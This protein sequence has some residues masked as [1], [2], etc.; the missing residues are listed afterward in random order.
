MNKQSLTAPIA[1]TSLPRPPRTRGLPLVGSLP[2]F[3]RS[4]FRFLL[5]ARAR[6]GDLYTLDVGFL[7]LVVLNHPRQV[8]HVL[9]DNSRN[10]VRK[11]VLYDSLRA[12]S[13]DGLIG[14]DGEV[15]LRQRRMVQPHF[16]R[17]QLA[18]L[19]DLLVATIVEE[20]DAWAPAAK[21]GTPIDLVPAYG[22]ITM[23]VIVRALFGTALTDTEIETLSTEIAYVLDHLF[24]DALASSLPRWLSVP[25]VRR[26]RQAR[27]VVDA[28][29]YDVIARTRRGDGGEG[30]LMT[31]MLQLV[32]AETGAQMTDQQLRDEAV[33]LVL[34]GYETTSIT[35]AWLG[36]LLTQHPAVL[37]KLQAEVDGLD[38]RRPTFAD[39]PS[40]RYAGMVVQEALRLYPAAWVFP[41]QAEADDVLD[42]HAIKA[43]TVIAITPYSI[44][45]N[46]ELWDE[47][48]RFD[49]ERFTPER[50]A[51]RHRHAWLAF[52]LGQHQCLGK[53]F[54]LM[55]AQLI[56]ALLLQRYG[57]EEVPGRT[58]EPELSST[59]RPK[60]GVWIAL[61]QRETASRMR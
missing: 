29:M 60:G 32:D 17:K 50:S 46:P 34:A 37:A 20:L 24:L 18:T 61:T 51:G 59:L 47:P 38:G 52:G 13:G 6:Y 27:T 26:Y 53:D 23:K 16:H 40:L 33:S 28:A 14:S 22:R 12:F 54:A 56:L 57:I 49:P 41:R 15:W 2:A 19:T 58:A 8:E 10:Y 9:Q 11:G 42:G 25:G 36:Q 7:Q 45:R 5:E 1:G 4:P 35:L 3:V 30:S 55:E 44:H 43:G 39:L 31:M 48:E 21:Q